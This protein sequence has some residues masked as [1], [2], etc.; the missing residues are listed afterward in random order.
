MITITFPCK[1][2]TDP[3]PT[4]H[5]S[6]QFQHQKPHQ[7]HTSIIIIITIILTIMTAALITTSPFLSFI[8]HSALKITTKG[9][10]IPISTHHT[11]SAISSRIPYLA[12]I[13][14]PALPSTHPST[15][16]THSY[17]QGPVIITQKA[18]FFSYLHILSV[19][20]NTLPL[21][22]FSPLPP[23]TTHIFRRIYCPLY[24]FIPLLHTL[25]HTHPAP[26]P[27]PPSL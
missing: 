23:T 26:L 12:S 3:S 27:L 21:S 16:P 7:L 15:R 14:S 24:F 6:C 13:N 19:C 9:Y 10:P 1:N 8:I 25:T 5:Q 2:I 18:T 20:I 22:P 17:F 11:Q 4:H